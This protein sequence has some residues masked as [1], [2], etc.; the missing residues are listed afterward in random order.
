[1][2]TSG[3]EYTRYIK[4]NLCAGAEMGPIFFR[5]INIALTSLSTP[6]KPA[7]NPLLTNTFG[8]I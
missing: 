4:A 1:M 6:H 3:F 2:G 5:R 7:L 8:D